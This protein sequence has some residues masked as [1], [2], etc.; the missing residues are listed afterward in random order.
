MFQVKELKDYIEFLKPLVYCSHKKFYIQAWQLVVDNIA[1]G[2]V[3]VDG[4]EAPLGKC[5]E[6]LRFIQT[7]PILY[8]LKFCDLVERLIGMRRL[9]C[10]AVLLQ[11]LSE[12]DR[13]KY[14]RVSGGGV[15]SS[16][17]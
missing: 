2:C 14:G 11:Y 17:H 7:C 16:N 13:D 6:A 8:S 12:S 5:V 1:S 10:A 15:N 9:E 3:N 4:I